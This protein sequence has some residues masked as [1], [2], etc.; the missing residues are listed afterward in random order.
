VA[1]KIIS[2][3]SVGL[4]TA[5]IASF[6]RTRLD[7]AFWPLSDAVSFENGAVSF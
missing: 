4:S 2:V 3:D 1:A 6:P 5:D 7:G